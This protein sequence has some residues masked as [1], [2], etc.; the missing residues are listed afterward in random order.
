MGEVELMQYIIIGA[1]AGGC[2]L[3]STLICLVIR[4]LR[5]GSDTVEIDPEVSVEHHDTEMSNRQAELNSASDFN[6]NETHE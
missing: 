1:A 6:E 2:L 3:V 5:K 4:C